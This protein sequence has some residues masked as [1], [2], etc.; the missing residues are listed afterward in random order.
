MRKTDVFPILF[1]ILCGLLVY[2]G[3]F[4]PIETPVDARTVITVGSTPL[5]GLA[6]QNLSTTTDGYATITV[7]TLEQQV[8]LGSGLA[9]RNYS[10]VLQTSPDGA[11]WKAANASVSLFALTAAAH[12]GIMATYSTAWNDFLEGTLQLSAML[13]RDDLDTAEDV[14][15]IYSAKYGCH[16]WQFGFDSTN[17]ARL[18]YVIEMTGADPDY[19]CVTTT[20]TS[21]ETYPADAWVEVAMLRTGSAVY[22]Y[23]NG[24]VEASKSGATMLNVKTDEPITARIGEGLQGHLAALKL[25]TTQTWPTTGARLIDS[26]GYATPGAYWLFPFAEGAGTTTAEVVTAVNFSIQTGTTWATIPTLFF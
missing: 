18:T 14:L 25:A 22:F 21:T 1:G 20:I 26:G 2:V 7:D 12:T 3:L 5:S 11:T 4:A 16:L 9:L 13:K 6:L 24:V 19:T 23:R 17:H 8:T 15:S 10:G